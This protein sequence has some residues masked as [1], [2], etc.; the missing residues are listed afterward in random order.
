MLLLGCRP[1]GRL[2]EQHDVFFGI[3]SSLKELIPAIKAFWPEAKGNIHIDAFRKVTQVGKFK[4]NV[5]E[6]VKEDDKNTHAL[7]FI[8]LG[9]YKSGEFDEFHY[10]ML[11]VAKD[12][13]DAVIQSKETTFYKH[14]GF[15]GAPS[16]IDDKYG[17]DVDD[18]YEVKDI[19]PE[20]FRSQY[21]LQ[22]EEKEGSEDETHLGYFRLDKLE[23]L[24]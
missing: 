16:H 4:I 20:W 22:I 15:T 21:S 2:T 18:L 5:R 17:V 24:Y 23:G 6:R 9:G 14:T 3:A 13:A 19:L 1:P 8:N 7:F 12:K 11:V 10:K